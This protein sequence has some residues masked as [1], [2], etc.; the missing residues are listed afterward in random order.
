MLRV[1]KQKRARKG[2]EKKRV[3]YIKGYLSCQWKQQQQQQHQAEQ[4]SS[5]LL[6]CPCDTD[7]K[8]DYA[9]S[10]LSMNDYVV[11][12]KVSLRCRYQNGGSF[13]GERRT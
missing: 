1:W 5:E 13:L 3:K 12:R 11:V 2:R 4:I 9:K 8:L 7:K 6:P 10:D